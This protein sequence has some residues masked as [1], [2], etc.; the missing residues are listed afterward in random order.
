MS[1]Y[2]I[3]RSGRARPQGSGWELAI[4]YLMRLTGIGLFVLALAH[5]I[6]VHFIFDPSDQTAEWVI[7]ERW[8]S[9]ALRTIDWLMLVFVLFHAFMGVRTVIGDYTSGGLRTALTM[10][11]Y[12]VGLLLLAMGTM[13]VFTVPLP[14]VP[15]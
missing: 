11:L 15:A 10:L 1:G 4:W 2:R 7:N 8:S 14:Q 6:V 5:Y 12:L 9:V 13:V 3:T